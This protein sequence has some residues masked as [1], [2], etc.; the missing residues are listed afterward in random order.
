MEAL[1]NFLTFNSNSFAVNEP[2]RNILAPAK[3]EKYNLFKH[4]QY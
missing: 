3:M 4:R 1:Q 2:L